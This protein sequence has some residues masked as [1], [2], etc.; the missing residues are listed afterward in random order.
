M[1][2][3]PYGF[4]GK[5]ENRLRQ[6]D[7][8]KLYRRGPFREVGTGPFGTRFERPSD[9]KGKFSWEGSGPVFGDFRRPGTSVIEGDLLCMRIEAHIMG[10]KYCGE[11]YRNPKGSPGTNDEYMRINYWGLFNFSMKPLDYK[12]VGAS[13]QAKKLTGADI[14]A[15]YSGAKTTLT[16]GFGTFLIVW[17]ADG[18]MAGK[19]KSDGFPPDDGKWWVEGDRFCRKWVIWGDGKEKCFGVSLDGDLV[20][21]WRD[22]GF[23]MYP[24]STVTLTK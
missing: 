21:W 12:P 13:A 11:V 2:K 1:P 14:E 10:R 20:K 22:N 23:Q 9:G 15:A 7:L 24:D 17:K 5:A 19:E 8:E 18:T 6:A 4:E 16:T 3:W